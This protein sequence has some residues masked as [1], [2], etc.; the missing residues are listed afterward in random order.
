V[1]RHV[2]QLGVHFAVDNKCGSDAIFQ[3]AY[4]RNESFT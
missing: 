1:D 4:L 2:C 3:F